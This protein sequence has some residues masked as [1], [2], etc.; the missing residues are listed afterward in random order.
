MTVL[1]DSWGENQEDRRQQEASA[2]SDERAERADRDAEQDE[3]NRDGRRERWIHA[4]K[5]PRWG[6]RRSRRLFRVDSRI[7]TRSN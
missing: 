7:R 6:N 2:H 1:G 3:E 5:T 4:A